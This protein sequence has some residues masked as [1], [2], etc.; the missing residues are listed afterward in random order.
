VR[1][2]SGLNYPWMWKLD[3]T[4]HRDQWCNNASSDAYYGYRVEWIRWG[5][6]HAT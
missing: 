1:Q 3:D 6:Q 4:T 5:D 2:F